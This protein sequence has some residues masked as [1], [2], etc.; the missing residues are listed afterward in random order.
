MGDKSY[1][2]S[3]EE[4]KAPAEYVFESPLYLVRK[5]VFYGCKVLLGLVDS[6]S[7]LF[8]FDYEYELTEKGKYVW[9]KDFKLPEYKLERKD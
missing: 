3:E 6:V 5:P 8:G 7:Y 1:K 9:F 2:R 4:V